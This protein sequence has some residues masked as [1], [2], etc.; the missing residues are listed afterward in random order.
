MIWIDGELDGM[1]KASGA[2]R[3][4]DRDTH[5][6]GLTDDVRNYLGAGPDMD[7]AGADDAGR[8]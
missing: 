3:L 6:H 1:M 2:I 7:D 5:L 4:I 8:S